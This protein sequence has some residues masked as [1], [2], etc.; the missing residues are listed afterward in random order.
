MTSGSGP[1]AGIGVI[2]TR[3][4][5]QAAHFA[6]KLA[7]LGATPLIWPAIV[8]LPPADRST[9]DQV[10][11]HLDRYDIA[12]FV[13]ANAVEFGAP[14][15]WPKGLD[16]FA[17][18]AGTAE[19][20]AALGCANPQVPTSTFDTEGLLALPSLSKVKGRRVVIFRGEGGRELLGDELSKRGATVDYITC[21]RRAAPEAGAAG[22]VEAL[23][24][25]RA[26]ALTLT[27]SEGL[28]NLL[29]ALDARGRRLLAELP[30]FAPHQRIVERA[31]AAG[32][33]ATLTPPGDAG[34]MTGLLEWF[35][36]HPLHGGV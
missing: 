3:P 20:L 13:S 32:L 26:H 1:L 12:V 10:H 24:A 11:A 29:N 14:A 28:E 25:R 19:A 23:E 22:L 7:T 36:R 35:A 31:R 4:A 34:L 21:Y 8:I 17:P 27:S 2:I 16:V 5:R 30:A 15:R 18:G 9:L 6:E 33:P